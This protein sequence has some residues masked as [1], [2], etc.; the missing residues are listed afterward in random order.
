MAANYW[1]STQRKHWQFTKDQ[2]ATMRQNLEDEDPQLVHMY[3]LQQLR[4]LNIYFNQR[5]SSPDFPAYN[6][7]R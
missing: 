5:Q 1:E 3:P 7:K 6:H 2:L 4:H